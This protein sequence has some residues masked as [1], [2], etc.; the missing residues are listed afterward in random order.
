MVSVHKD[1]L[2]GACLV[3]ARIPEAQR[4][5]LTN[6]E[7]KAEFQDLVAWRDGIFQKHFPGAA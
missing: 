4:K 7:L 1:R 5:A 6:A 2:T 3:F